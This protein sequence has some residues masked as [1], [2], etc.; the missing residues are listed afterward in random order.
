MSRRQEHAPAARSPVSR[1]TLLPLFLALACVGSGVTVVQI[2][3]GSRNFTT[4]LDTLRRQRDHL[5]V[6]WAQLRLEQATLDRHGRVQQLAEKQFDMVEPKDYVIVPERATP[7]VTLGKAPAV[8][9][10]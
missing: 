8:V 5:Q 4:R 3:H 10:Q 6:E 1:G 2:K 7:P 9:R